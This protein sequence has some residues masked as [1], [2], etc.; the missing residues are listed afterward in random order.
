[1]KDIIITILISYIIGAI[2]VGY[3]VGKIFF[4]TDITKKGSGNI[5]F[6]N[7]AQHLGLKAAFAVFLLDYLEGFIAVLAVKLLF[8][9]PLLN[10]VAAL[11]VV[12]GHDFSVFM[13]FKGGKGASTTY[14]ALTVLSPLATLFGAFTFFGM[15]GIK[16]YISLSNLVS[17]SMIPVYM[18]FMKVN[19]YYIFAAFSLAV[20]L[21]YTHRKNIADL[22]SGKELK[23]T[24]S[25]PLKR[26]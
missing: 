26:K 18:V 2:P 9:T 23:I 13:K 25:E 20:L 15:L 19:K 6:A 16:K 7:V 22:I 5:G 10:A 11:M 17:I 1:M 21:I 12:V 3:I 4:K 14:G 8:N 24:N